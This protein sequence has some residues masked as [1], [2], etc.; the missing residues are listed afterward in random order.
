MNSDYDRIM[1]GKF[2]NLNNIFKQ[3]DKSE[4]LNDENMD[5]SQAKENITKEVLIRELKLLP[6]NSTLLSH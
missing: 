6:F 3:G 4:K 5:S 1:K 2:E